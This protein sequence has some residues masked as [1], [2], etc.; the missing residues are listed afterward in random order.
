MKNTIK[1]ILHISIYLF[2]ALSIHAQNSPTWKTV[3]AD[4]YSIKIPSNWTYNLDLP[5]RTNDLGLKINKHV[6]ATPQ[7]KGKGSIFVDII[8][9]DHN[10]GITINEIYEMDS[11]SYKKTFD[12]ISTKQITSPPCKLYYII[13]YQYNNP[14]IKKMEYMKYHSWLYEQDK[15][16]YSLTI[17]YEKNAINDFSNFSEIINNIQKSFTLK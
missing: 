6:Y 2:I 15:S 16:I 13:N 17:V 14:Y 10:K 12:G 7:E 3:N 11:L 1:Q 8:K 4:K 5:I 9:Y